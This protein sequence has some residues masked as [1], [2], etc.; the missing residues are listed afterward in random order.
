M[1][2]TW[3]GHC[4][5]L[6][7]DLAMGFPGCCLAAPQ[8]KAPAMAELL[9]HQIAC[10]GRVAMLP[11]VPEPGI[12]LQ[13]IFCQQITNDFKKK[14][15]LWILSTSLAGSAIHLLQQTDH[16]FA[17]SQSTAPSVIATS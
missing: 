5:Q 11:L 14:S 16:R 9:G 3:Q 7:L 13:K 10:P 4:A 17:P 8:R 2:F 1:M 6:P 15:T 12:S